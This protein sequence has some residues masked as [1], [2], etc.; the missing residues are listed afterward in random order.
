MRDIDPTVTFVSPSAVIGKSSYIVLLDG[1]PIHSEDTK[2]ECVGPYFAN[3]STDGPLLY[4]T[5]L[6]PKYWETLCKSPGTS[7]MSQ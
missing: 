1:A 5:P 4:G 3:S 7:C 6:V 2:L